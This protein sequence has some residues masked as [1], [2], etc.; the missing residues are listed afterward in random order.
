MPDYSKGVIYTI[1]YRGDPNL[2]YVGST[3][4]E[5]S[6]RWYDHKSRCFNV[7]SKGHKRLVYQ[8]IR[9]TDDIDNWYIELYEEFPCENRQQLNKKEGEII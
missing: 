6:K 8:K 7:N 9:E 5:L 2:I 3:V 1:R 4:N